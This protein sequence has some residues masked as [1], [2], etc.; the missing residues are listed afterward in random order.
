MTEQNIDLTINT[1][2]KEKYRELSSQGQI[3]ADQLYLIEDTDV[4]ALSADIGDGKVTINQG[5]TKKGEFTL[6]QKGD[7]TI[8]LA[9]GGGGGG[10][11]VWGSITGTLS[12]Q[13]DLNTAL[14]NKVTLKIWD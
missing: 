13:T 5:G 8:D 6:N 10:D 4:Y 7:V 2:S 1:L 12:A 14:N 11:A 9:S 3:Q